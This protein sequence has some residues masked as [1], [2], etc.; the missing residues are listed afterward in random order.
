MSSC[1]AALHTILYTKHTSLMNARFFECAKAS[2][3]YQVSLIGKAVKGLRMQPTPTAVFHR[4]YSLVREKRSSRQDFL[5]AI[6]KI[7]EI[8][9]SSLA[10]SQDEVDLSRYMAENISAL[11][12]KTQEE[13]L[14]VIRTLTSVL[15]VAGMPIYFAFTTSDQTNAPSELQPRDMRIVHGPSADAQPPQSIQLR[16]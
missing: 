14:T 9:P 3:D 5:K 7:F 10:C 8:D 12:Y 1:A 11:D 6:L 13:V 15:S 4:W 2:F 16:S